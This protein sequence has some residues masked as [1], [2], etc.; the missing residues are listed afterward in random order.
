MVSMHINLFSYGF[1]PEDFVINDF[2]QTLAEKGHT[3]NVITG[4][5][6]YPKGSFF[7]GY[8]LFRGPYRQ[9][10]G[11][12]KI[13]RYPIFPRKKGF[14]FLA[15]NY[16]SH[17]LGAVPLQ[18][19]IP[20]AEW[21]FV[22]AISPITIAIPAILWSK[23]NKKKIC[24]WI[25]DLWPDS[26]IAVGGTT[27]NSFTHKILSFLVQWIYSQMDLIFIQSP[28]FLESIERFK[29]QGPVH[30]I[31]NWAPSFDFQNASPPTW[32]HKKPN[33]FNITFAG[34]V[35]R[36]QDLETI[37]EIAEILRPQ[38]QIQFSIVG[39]GSALESLKTLV[40]QK[41]LYNVVF[42]GRRPLEDMPGLFKESEA[43]LVSLKRDPLFQKTIPSKLQ[44]YMA[45]G[46]PIV[47][48]LGG[49]GASLIN[50]IGCGVAVP[51]EDARVLADSILVMAQKSSAER[52]KMGDLGK[53]YFLDHFQKDAIINK[54]VDHLI[55]SNR[56]H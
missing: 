24:L 9:N 6:N 33:T 41:K 48:N 12:V 11:K 2:A 10:Y 34:N 28:A 46:K 23:L 51:V 40:S 44:S 29:Y 17:F 25:Q 42:Y 13:H 49:I 37:I 50:Q 30:Y 22:Y 35:G 39:E 54:I 38:T 4:L 20:K 18:F 5:P 45:A 26:V 27:Q 3:I 43:L 1:W 15:L 21:A 8:S 53:K 19:C 16:I 56:N 36:A 52:E 7:S 31:P 32:F 47:G 55:L 14:K